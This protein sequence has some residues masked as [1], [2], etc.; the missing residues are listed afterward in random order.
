MRDLLFDTLQLHYNRSVMQWLVVAV[1]VTQL[2][3]LSSLWVPGSLNLAHCT[4]PVTVH[5]R[6]GTSA[7]ISSERSTLIYTAATLTDENRD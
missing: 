1:T 3:S 7:S 6:R 2:F 5:C 4:Q